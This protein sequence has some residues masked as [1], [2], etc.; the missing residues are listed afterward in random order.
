[1][2]RVLCKIPSGS[3]FAVGS[4]AF[5]HPGISYFFFL[6]FLYS[7]FMFPLGLTEGRP[8]LCALSAVDSSWLESGPSILLLAEGLAIMQILT[9]TSRPQAVLLLDTVRPDLAAPF[10]PACN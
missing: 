1:M 10:C 4:W 2:F 5:Y 9:W 3:S 7:K 6:F 8:L